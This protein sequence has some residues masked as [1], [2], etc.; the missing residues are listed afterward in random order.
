[1]DHFGGIARRSTPSGRRE[2]QMAKGRH[3]PAV[4]ARDYSD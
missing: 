1:M 2:A 3:L 4:A